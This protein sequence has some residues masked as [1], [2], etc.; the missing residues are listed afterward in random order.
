MSPILEQMEEHV[1]LLETFFKAVDA[2]NIEDI[3]KVKDLLHDDVVLNKIHD[4]TSTVRGKDKVVEFLAEKM[5]THQPRLKP[6]TPVSVDSRTGTVS[7]VA[8]WE[9]HEPAGDIKELVDYSFAFTLGAKGWLLNNMYA[10]PRESNK[11]KIAS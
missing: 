9:D 6:I 8:M 2:L 1:G 5:K 3:G 7:G 4:Q 10:S 11:I